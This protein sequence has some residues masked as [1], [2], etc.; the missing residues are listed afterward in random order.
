[1]T[2]WAVDTGNNAVFVCDAISTFQAHATQTGLPRFQNSRRRLHKLITEACLCFVAGRGSGRWGRR[3]RKQRVG[4]PRFYSLRGRDWR[5]LLR[6]R[7]SRDPGNSLTGN[8][9]YMCVY[10]YIYIYIYKYMYVY[11]CIYICLYICIY[12]Y[13][14]IYLS[15]YNTYLSICLSMFVCA[16]GQ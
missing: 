1:M 3:H 10:I 14:S 8:Y 4:G 9:L 12:V 2:D 13:L 7:G 15:I 11:A 16:H 5:G 6:P